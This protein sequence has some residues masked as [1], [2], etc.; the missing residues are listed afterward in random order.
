MPNRP[1]QLCRRCNGRG[2]T[3]EPGQLAPEKCFR[4]DG[5]GRVTIWQARSLAW[6]PII[7]RK[8]ESRPVA[9]PLPFQPGPQPDAGLGVTKL[10]PRESA[11]LE[12]RIC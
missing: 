11:E 9:L 10:S 8:R 2:W 1:S 7:H 6:T 4:C 12:R 5:V 3:H